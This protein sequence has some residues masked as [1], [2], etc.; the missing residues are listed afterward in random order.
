MASQ[1]CFVV[2]NTILA[3]YA[4]WIEHLGGNL[5]DVGYINGAG[6]ILGLLI[7]P[8]LGQWINRYGAKTLWLIGYLVFASSSLANLLLSD[9]GL[10]IYLA[11]SGLLAGSAIVFSSGLAYISQIA[12]EN[13][14]AEGI[15]ILGAAGFIG[16]LLGPYLGDW[17]LGPKVE[18]AF[19]DRAVFTNLFLAASIANIVPI[20]ILLFV[21]STGER[22]IHATT[23]I[24][25][26]FSTIKLHWPGPIV[27]VVFV[28]GVCITVPFVFLASYIDE[29][30]LVIGE[31][32]VM[33]LFFL[34]YGGWG[35]ILRVICRRLPDQV[36]ARKV[37]LAGMAFMS[38]GMF[39]FV[40]VEESRA[41]MIVTPALLTGTGHSLIYHS[42]ASLAMEPFPRE[43]HGT[44]SVLVSITLDSGI[45]IGAAVL[46]LIGEYLGFNWLF[47][48]IGLACLICAI[49]FGLSRNR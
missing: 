14:R 23:S 11:R 35:F 41:W 42:M 30:P 47:S 7:R 40:L 27:G 4:R 46:G 13:R 34:C 24:R 38:I 1:V 6:V 29:T 20:I 9:I 15:G 26:F 28:F 8:W 33:G 36:G 44:G 37:L 31:H 10:P 18:G 43:L 2:A 48:S 25:G 21:R 45:L 32:S 19:R 49:H 22:A 5:T 39:A 17:L 12:P 16:M 3:H